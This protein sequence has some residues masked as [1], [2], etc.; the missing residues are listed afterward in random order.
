MSV[1]EDLVNLAQRWPERAAT[2][3]EGCEADHVGC[4]VKKLARDVER[5]QA[6]VRRLKATNE[7]ERTHLKRLVCVQFAEKLRLEDGWGPCLMTREDRR[8]IDAIVEEERGIAL[9][10]SAAAAEKTG[11]TR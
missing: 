6:E 11:G 9:A 8:A 3:Y 1:S 10:R 7:R 4:L 5:L 2:H